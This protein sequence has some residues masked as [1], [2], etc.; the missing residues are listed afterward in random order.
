MLATTRGGQLGNGERA[1]AADHEIR[2][3]VLR[4]HVIDEGQRL[5]VHAGLRVIP[6]QACRDASRPTGA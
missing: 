1:G 4:G 6:L 2:L 3:A 5:R